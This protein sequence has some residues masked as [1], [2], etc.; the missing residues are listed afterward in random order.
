MPRDDK[1]RGKVTGYERRKRIGT[2]LPNAQG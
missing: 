1:E 2:E